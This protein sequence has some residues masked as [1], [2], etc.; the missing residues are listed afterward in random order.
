MSIVMQLH[1]ETALMHITDFTSDS[2]LTRLNSTILD[3]SL[4]ILH[5]KVFS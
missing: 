1:I 4:L 3:L 5:S 2:A